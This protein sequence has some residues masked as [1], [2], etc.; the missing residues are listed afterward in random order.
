ML[1]KL[2]IGAFLGVLA[3]F[4]LGG[5][6][7]TK[8]KATL[9]HRRICKEAAKVLLQHPEYADNTEFLELQIMSNIICSKE[10]SEL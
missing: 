9:E 3:L 1:S 5:L 8:H 6:I 4:V 7:Y 10:D 2:N